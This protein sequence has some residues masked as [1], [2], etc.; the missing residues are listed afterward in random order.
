MSAE[1]KVQ[2]VSTLGLLGVAFVVLKLVGVISWSWWWVTVPFWGPLGI[3]AG[4]CVIY[5]LAVILAAIVQVFIN[6]VGR[7]TKKRKR[8]R[9]RKRWTMGK[10]KLIIGFHSDLDKNIMQHLLEERERTKT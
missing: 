2:G 6:L 3:I 7:I 9:L 1:V 4:I 5:I 8:R 10:T